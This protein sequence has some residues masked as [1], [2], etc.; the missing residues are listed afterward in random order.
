MGE[1][2]WFWLLL[3]TTVVV[4][5]STVASVFFC[6]SGCA[7]YLRSC[8]YLVF[9]CDCC[10]FLGLCIH[11]SCCVTWEVPAVSIFIIASFT[12]FMSLACSPMRHSSSSMVFGGC[13]ADCIF[14]ID[15]KLSR[16][17]FHVNLLIM[18]LIVSFSLSI[19][20]SLHPTVIISFQRFMCLLI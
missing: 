17:S 15:R 10:Y 4:A 16:I 12:S 14:H 20:I 6:C 11:C 5:L 13:L 18:C 8:T 3:V 9:R 19:S 7:V 1:G 2:L